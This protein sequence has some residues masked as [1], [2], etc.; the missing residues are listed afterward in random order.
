MDISFAKV[1]LYPEV[2]TG[3]LLLLSFVCLF[4]FNLPFPR[5]GVTP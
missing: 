2:P 5:Q 3:L 1:Y 4:V